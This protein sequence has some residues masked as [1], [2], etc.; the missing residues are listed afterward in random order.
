MEIEAIIEVSSNIHLLYLTILKKV[1]K[2][3]Q[4]IE[5][6]VLIRNTT[7]FSLKLFNVDTHVLG[8]EILSLQKCF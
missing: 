1:N 7:F 8:Y 2:L 3:L 6:T 4:N 5:Q